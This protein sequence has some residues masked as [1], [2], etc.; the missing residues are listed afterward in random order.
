MKWEQ[1]CTTIK[2][3]VASLHRLLAFSLTPQGAS[4]GAC[5]P[6]PPW[7]HNCTFLLCRFTLHRIHLEHLNAS[8]LTFFCF[9]FYVIVFSHTMRPLERLWWLLRSGCGAKKWCGAKKN[10]Q[11]MHLISFI[12]FLAL[13]AFHG[14]CFCCCCRLLLLSAAASTHYP[15]LRVTAA[16]PPAT[17]RTVPVCGM[18]YALLYVLHVK[19]RYV[20]LPLR[21]QVSDGFC[22]A[23][24]CA[25]LL[26][27]HT[28]SEHLCASKFWIHV[29]FLSLS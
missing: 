15:F 27:L 19:S 1:I 11:S 21:W 7:F 26:L 9:F 18:R 28:F 25:L 10:A 17:R 24:L 29:F 3:S 4:E 13:P 12:E 23:Y 14:A 8:L 2:K 22:V 6:L 5:T 16:R 20:H